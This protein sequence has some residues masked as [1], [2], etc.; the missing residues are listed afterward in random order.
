MNN[1]NNNIGRRSP[2]S[3]RII[4]YIDGNKNKSKYNH[5]S[6]I[7]NNNNSIPNIEKFDNKEILDTALKGLKIKEIKNN[8]I[9]K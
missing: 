1:Y 2:M 8:F 9:T 7:N 4:K 5:F 3:N 6:Y